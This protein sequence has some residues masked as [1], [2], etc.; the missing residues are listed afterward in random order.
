MSVSED[1]TRE[2]IDAMK[3][4]GIN[5]SQL[6]EKMGLSKSHIS[7]LLIGDRNMRLSTVERLGEALNRKVDIVFA[8]KGG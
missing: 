8:E 1:I 7:R 4:E 2:I 6:A 3:E 5:R